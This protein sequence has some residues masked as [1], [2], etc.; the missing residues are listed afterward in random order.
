MPGNRIR[1]LVVLLTAIVALPAPSLGS[2]QQGN[3]ATEKALVFGFLPILSTEKLVARFG[4]MSDYMAQKLG[5]P[6]RF[7]TAA[8]Y[9]EFARR[10][11]RDKRYDILFTAPHF[12]YTAQRQAGPPVGAREQTSPN[13]QQHGDANLGSTQPEHQAAH[14]KQFGQTE[15]QANAE[16]QED[17][18]KFGEVT[19]FFAIANQSK[20]IRTDQNTDQQISQQRR[21]RE[22]TEY[23]HHRDSGK[24][25]YQDQ[26]KCAV[27]G[28]WF[29]E[30]GY[31]ESSVQ[32]Y[33]HRGVAYIAG[34]PDNVDTAAP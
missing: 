6:V 3:D 32:V 5:R 34:L 2:A 23:R 20:G 16:H 31:K 4:P 21:Q 13:H 25:Q 7:E 15:L 29:R 12:Y 18:A 27:H 8:G 9:A 10:T 28:P 14:G 1:L 22:Q 30:T 33:R 26:F 11:N 24:Q 17:H 19:G